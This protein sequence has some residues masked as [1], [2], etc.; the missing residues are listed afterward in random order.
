VSG[1][2][3][4]IPELSEPVPSPAGGLRSPQV[5]VAVGASETVGVGT[6]NPYRDAWPKVLWRTA[7]PQ[8]TVY[9]GL[10]VAGT[11]IRRALS[12]QLPTALAAEPT[13]ATVWLNVNDLNAGV[14]PS[15]YEDRLRDL[16]HALR[17]GGRTT[18]LV[19]NTP[20]LDGL[21]LYRACLGGLADVGRACEAFGL[22]ISSFDRLRAV[23]RA[24]NGAIERVAA[25]EGAI[26]VDL[27]A[28]SELLDADPELVAPDGFH[29]STEGA[30]VVAEAFARALETASA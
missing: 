14:R 17:R 4:P 8:G 26:V 22:R 9:V 3:T 24:Y 19:A 23:V 20:R 28:R 16:V 25:A 27:F 15:V 10:G 1:A 21:P 6:H 2:P 18:V 13:I 7:M 11:T 29:P 12:E 5:Y 30:V